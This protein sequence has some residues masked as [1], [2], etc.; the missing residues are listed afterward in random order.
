MAKRYKKSYHNPPSSKEIH[1]RQ[2][3]RFDKHLKETLSKDKFIA[4][5]VTSIAVILTILRFGRNC[6]GYT[7]GGIPWQSRLMVGRL[8]E[9]YTLNVSRSLILSAIV[10]FFVYNSSFQFLRNRRR[11]K[12]WW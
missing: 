9:F 10:I 12:F 4:I 2:E 1:K 5:L 7:Q 8:C 11:R 3:E 6:E